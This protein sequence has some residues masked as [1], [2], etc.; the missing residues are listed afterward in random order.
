MIL[1]ERWVFLCDLV[2]NLA[3]EPAV[4]A[5]GTAVNHEKLCAVSQRKTVMHRLL[6]IRYISFA[7]HYI[8]KKNIS[9]SVLFIL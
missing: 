3:V 9:F 2:S 7:V 6:E 4:Y 5:R 1:L 8:C